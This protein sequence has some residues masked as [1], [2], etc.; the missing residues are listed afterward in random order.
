MFRPLL[1]LASLAFT[2]APAI[3]ATYAARPA[4]PVQSGKII[5]RD[6]V[7]ACGPDAC[8][9]STDNSRPLVLCQGLAKKAG[10]IDSFIVN[11]RAIADDEL[12][13]CNASAKRSDNE[14]LANAR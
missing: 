12:A 11:G 5:G 8:V 14:A 4:A 7:W 2:A 3:A 6:I 10:P 9:G 1:A 13:R